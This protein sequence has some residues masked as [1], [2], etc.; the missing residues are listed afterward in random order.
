[1]DVTPTIVLPPLMTLQQAFVSNQLLLQ[2]SG[3]K[4]WRMQGALG[5]LGVCPLLQDYF[6]I[7]QFSGNSKRKPPILSKFWAQ[8]PLG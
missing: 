5:A 6:K 4:H 3:K 2:I 1:M 8:A 7:M